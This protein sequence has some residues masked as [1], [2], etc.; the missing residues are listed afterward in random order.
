MEKLKSYFKYNDIKDY[1]QEIET[2]KNEVKE[3]LY[4]AIKIK[5]IF[6]NKKYDMTYLQF[7]EF[8]KSIE[9]LK[10]YKLSYDFFHNLTF[11]H[12]TYNN[13]YINTS[14]IYIPINKIE[15]DKVNNISTN[16]NNLGIFLKYNKQ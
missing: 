3:L 14:F 2:M 8:I 10:N 1:K 12:L 7:K 16:S 11:R 13:V 5:I 9:I 15:L 4:P 6:E